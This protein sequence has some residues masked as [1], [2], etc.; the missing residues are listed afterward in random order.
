MS[1]PHITVIGGGLAGPEAASAAAGQGA[2]ATLYEMKPARFSPAHALPAL[3][4]L[5]CSNSLGSMAPGSAPGLLKEEL[6]RLGSLVI[7]AALAER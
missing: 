6:Q 1:Q 5:V 7:G 4:E 3:G 2:R